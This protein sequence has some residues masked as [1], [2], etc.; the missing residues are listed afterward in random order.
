MTL[1]TAEDQKRLKAKM[2]ERRILH[3]SS[4]PQGP[5][6]LVLLEDGRDVSHDD[7]SVWVEETSIF[8]FQ[9]EERQL[10]EDF[11]KLLYKADP[12]R[13]DVACLVVQET[14]RPTVRMEFA[15]E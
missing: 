3:L 7:G 9:T 5:H 6:L 15:F 1:F 13:T 10:W 14:P 12:S 11:I 2:K 8:A 4:L